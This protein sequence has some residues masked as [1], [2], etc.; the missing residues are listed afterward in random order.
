VFRYIQLPKM[1]GVLMIAV[2]LRFMDSFMIYT[3]PFVL[4]GGGPGNATFLS[5]YLTQKAVGQFDLGPGGVLADLF[6]IILLFCFVLYNWMQRVGQAEKGGASHAETRQKRTLFLVLYLVFALL[7]IYWMVNMSF[8]TNEEILSGF[9]SGPALH[10][11]QLRHHLHRRELVLGLH[12]QPDL[13]GQH[14]DLDHRGA[15]GGLCL[16]ALQLPR[17]QACVLLA[18]DQPHDAA[19]GVPAAVLPALHHAGPDGHAHRG[20]A[21]APAVQR[22]AG[23]VDSGRLHVGIPR[24]IDETAYID[25]YSFPRFFLTI[26]LPL[27]KAGV[28]VAAFF[29]FMFSWVELLL[30]RTLTSVNAKPIVA[31]MTR[32]VSASGM[33]WATLAAAGVLTIVPGAIVIWFVGTT[34]PR[35]SPWAGCEPPTRRREMFD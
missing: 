12:Q 14:G 28:G 11:G 6:L 30:A 22:A 17:R 29:C 23:G 21:G 19:G 32:T 31:T 24:E 26:F 4:T 34:S 1:R 15:A 3:E 2:L 33:D 16:L 7:P 20:G 18:A 25:G 5:Q 10:L 9:S 8:K 13:R 27:I 35:A